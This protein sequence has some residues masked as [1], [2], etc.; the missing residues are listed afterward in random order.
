MDVVSVAWQGVE[1]NTLLEEGKLAAIPLLVFANKQDLIS[2][3]AA[4]EVL[5]CSYPRLP[6]LRG[7][8]IVAVTFPCCVV[9]I[10]L[11]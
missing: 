1:L 2:A 11:Q 7:T 9:H 4:K 6:L 8:Y 10:L 3:M 5:T